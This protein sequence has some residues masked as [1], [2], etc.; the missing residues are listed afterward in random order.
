MNLDPEEFRARHLWREGDTTAL[1]QRV[2]PFGL[3]SAFERAR[4]TAR[5]W[6]A[7]APPGHGVGVAGGFWSTSTGAGGEVRLRLGPERLVVLQGEREIGSGSVLGGLTAVAIRLTGL[8]RG[9]IDIEYGDTSQAPF[10][11]GVFGSRTLG[12]L[13]RA[14]EEAVVALRRTLAERLGAAGQADLSVENGE[15]VANVG[16]RRASVATLINEDE[17]A[18]GGILA[19]GRH[20]APPRAIDE[21]RVLQGTFYPYTDFTGAAHVAEVSVDSAT[22]AVH[23]ERYAAFHDA[24]TVVDLGA[25]RAQVEGGVAMGLGAALTEEAIWSAE[26]RLENAGLLDYRIPTL[27]EVPPLTIEFLEGDMGAGPFGA[28]GLGEP[29][30]VPVPAAVAIA[31]RDACGAHATELPLSAERVARALKLL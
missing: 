21:H 17:R 20:Y 7:A 2:G 3:A 16:T 27:S 23:V 9:R 22:G 8:P 1:G 13:G 10:D 14:T 24:G 15:I 26:G 5:E 29:P 31:V 19:E 25:A 28:K 30:I 12:A 18:A 6:R 4:A 11:S